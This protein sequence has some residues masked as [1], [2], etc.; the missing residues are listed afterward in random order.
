MERRS[1]GKLLAMAG[2]SVLAEKVF[3]S[4]KKKTASDMPLPEPVKGQSSV[5]LC[6]NSRVSTHG[7][8]SGAL[9]E[10][11]MANV[12][13][14]AS[15]APLIASERTVYVALPEGVY[16][17]D[18][19]QHMLVFHLDGN[20]RSESNTAFEVGVSTTP[21]GVAEDAGA[22]L[23][24]A[25]LASIPFWGLSADLP[26]SCP[27]DSAY[28]YANLYWNPGSTIHLVNCYGRLN[29]VSGFKTNLV[30]HSSDSSLPDPCVNGSM[31]LEDAM[32]E[33]LYGNHFL[34][35]AL[36][37]EE[38][39]QIAW[40][41]Y[42]CTPHTISSKAG[43]SVASWN[44]MYYLTGH[45]YIVKPGSV[46]R[47][48]MRQL[49]GAINTRDHRTEEVTTEDRRVQLRAAIPRISQ[50]APVYFLFC[51]ETKERPQLLEA[52]YCGSSAL[53]QATALGLQG[54]YCGAFNEHER[55]AI[56]NALGISSQEQPLVIFCAGKGMSTRVRSSVQK[57]TVL[58]GA[59]PNPFFSA[60][61]IS[62]VSGSPA[63]ITAAIYTINGKKIRALSGS[64]GA[65]QRKTI[66]WDGRDALG[67]AVSSGM[68][69]CKIA[70][71]DLMKTVLLHKR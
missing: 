24:W 14:A 39:S 29:Q 57:E 25:Q 41:A 65:S 8:Y 62:V 10:Q 59:K 70:G 19:R 54:C 22:A 21:S 23:H 2:T 37:A 6:L 66:M 26:A 35:D 46:H 63:R 45:V 56:V 7:G 67:R 50:S 48:H 33:P 61:E 43:L 47:Y 15:R 34:A 69:I 9:S 27:K 53:L 49:S 30:A 36:S 44:A 28:Q 13:W 55:E 20:Q 5:E 3:S 64:G 12:V 71:A 17:Y 32:E 42:G 1:F 51:A 16:R 18:P 31:P 38:I 52:G 11:V 4:T 68:Y 58:V 40:A 60:T